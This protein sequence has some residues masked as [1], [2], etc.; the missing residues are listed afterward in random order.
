MSPYEA[1]GPNNLDVMKGYW[2]LQ[3]SLDFMLP[4]AQ[5]LAEKTHLEAVQQAARQAALDGAVDF[6]LSGL[7]EFESSLTHLINGIRSRANSADDYSPSP[8]SR[9][10][11]PT[12][13]T[14]SSS[15]K[16]AIPAPPAEAPPA[17]PSPEEPPKAEPARGRAGSGHGWAATDADQD[18]LPLPARARKAP[19]ASP[20]E[21]T[22]MTIQNVPRRCTR[23]KVLQRLEAAGLRSDVDFLY[24]PIDLKSNCNV[25]LAIVNLRT[26]DAAERLTKAFHKVGIKVAFPGNSG[27]KACEVVPAKV[28]GRDANVHRL[29]Q[30]GLLLSLL[31]GKPEWMPQLFDEESQPVPFP[32]EPA[33]F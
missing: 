14:M 22:T 9:A 10:P 2:D 25:G 28:Q 24:V 21:I 17:E 12:S 8:K 23:A 29:Q 30:S 16:D 1:F 33:Q 7:E 15:Q 3:P 27:A 11:Q 5:D 13:P 4:D 19:A 6:K 20:T 31:A 32:E 18:L 26:E